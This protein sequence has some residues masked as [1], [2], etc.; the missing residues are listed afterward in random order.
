MI[1]KIHLLSLILIIVTTQVWAQEKQKSK[2]DLSSRPND[3]FIV[4]L[5]SDS[6]LNAPDSISSHMSGFHRG[7]HVYFM[8]D[9]PFKSNPKLS[10]GFGAGISSS[11]MYFENM[12]VDV[13]GTSTP[14]VFQETDSTGSFK[15]YKLNTTYIEAPLELRF[16]SKPEHPN[17]SIKIAIGIKAATILNAHTKGKSYQTGAGDLIID[18][19][20]KESSKKYFNPTR[21]AATFR[22]N[23]GIFGLTGSYSLTP[24]LKNGVGSQDI[25]QLQIGLSLSGL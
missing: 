20:Q 12:V 4:Q 22:M 19:I 11:N 8:L 15:K 24:L 10:F 1:M 18:G 14:L 7:L 21:L 16:S 9:K 23:Y 17:R 3:H 25:R 5:T 13:A 2:P 6:W